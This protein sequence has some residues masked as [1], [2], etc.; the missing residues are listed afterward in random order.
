MSDKDWGS[1]YLVPVITA[2]VLIA[3]SYAIYRHTQKPAREPDVI[4]T[5]GPMKIRPEQF[6]AEMIRRGG[7]S[8]E[9]IDKQKLLEEMIGYEAL[10][11]KALEAGLDKD[12]EIVRSYHN[13]LVGRL[14]QR[15][16]TPEIEAAEVTDDD[17]K[18]YY[19]ANIGTF[20]QPEKIRVAI[21]YM[22]TDSTMSGEKRAEIRN[23]MERAREKALNTEPGNAPGF[24]A[25]AVD[26]SEDQA[27]RYSGG[28]I[29][30]LSRGRLYRWDPAVVEA[31]FS[32]AQAGDVSGIVATDTGFYFVKLMD[33]KE[34]AVTPLEKVKDRI[35]HKVLL[36]KRKGI[37]SAFHESI[38]A[39]VA[40]EIFPE[41]LD[42]VGIPAGKDWKKPPNLP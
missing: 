33:R 7:V 35:R 8:P 17:M 6:K 19:K 1:R 29:G 39:S 34:S 4:A 23:K 38:R 26:Y 37:E 40:V 14:R 32:L 20:T 30:W 3:A 11:V 42:A 12:P 25:L 21:L 24:G 22:K 2:I 36:E 9:I 18:A 28:D 10:L 16:L 13:L 31:G 41:A 27:S 5:V 15:D